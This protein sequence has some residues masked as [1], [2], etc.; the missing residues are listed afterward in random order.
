MFREFNNHVH[1][2]IRTAQAIQ[3]VE[4]HVYMD[5]EANAHSIYR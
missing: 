5:V 3:L 1:L 2:H 4:Y